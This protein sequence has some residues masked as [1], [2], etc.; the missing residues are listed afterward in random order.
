MRRPRLS[1]LLVIINVGVLLLAVAGVAVAAAS[2]LQRF[3]DEQALARVGQASATARQELTRAGED[4]LISARLLGERPTLL[5]L[6]QANQINELADFLA[7]FQQTSQ[8]DGCAVLRDGQVVAASGAELPWLALAAQ[9][10]GDDRLL[11]RAAPADA[12][13]QGARA[14]CALHRRAER[15]PWRWHCD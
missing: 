5:R 1:T 15:R 14:R 2:L 12:L 9:P 3:A 6:L 10:P 4:A 8:L 13:L 7:Q 11:Y